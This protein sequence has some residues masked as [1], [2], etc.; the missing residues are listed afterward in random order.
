MLL[1]GS[2]SSPS[3]FNNTLITVYDG[4]CW[5][6]LVERSGSVSIEGDVSGSLVSG[7]VKGR[8]EYRRVRAVSTCFGEA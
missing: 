5:L 4:L 2:N 7:S 1:Y 6:V 3:L 8:A